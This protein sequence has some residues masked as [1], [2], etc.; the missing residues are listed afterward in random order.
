MNDGVDASWMTPYPVP[1]FGGTIA[2]IGIVCLIRVFSSALWPMWVWAS[3][4]FL[5]L[6]AISLMAVM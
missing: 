5:T 2:M 1:I 4:V 6:V 3:A